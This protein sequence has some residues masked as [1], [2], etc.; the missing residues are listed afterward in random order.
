MEGAGAGKGVGVLHF[1]ATILSGLVTLTAFA[2]R[3]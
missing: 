1:R 2:Y 3:G